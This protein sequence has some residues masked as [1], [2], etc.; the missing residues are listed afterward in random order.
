MPCRQE[1]ALLGFLEKLS[2]DDVRKYCVSLIAMM[3]SLT[4]SG[5]RMWGPSIIGV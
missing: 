5:P 4:R 2:S 3:R 1:V